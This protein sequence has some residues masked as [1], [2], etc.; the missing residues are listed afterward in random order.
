MAASFSRSSSPSTDEPIAKRARVDG[1]ERP[2]LPTS[3]VTTEQHLSPDESS[4]PCESE[5]AEVERQMALPV[6]YPRTYAT[7][8]DYRNKLVLAPMVRTGTR[9]FFSPSS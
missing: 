5:A 7:E 3:A 6:E 4:V 1:S 2:R 8:L 9:T